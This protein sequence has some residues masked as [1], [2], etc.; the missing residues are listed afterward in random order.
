MI[1]D[2]EEDRS[3]EIRPSVV[4]IFG[5]NVGGT[6]AILMQEVDDGIEVGKLLENTTRM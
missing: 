5:T 4:K 6:D 2:L 1:D 3:H